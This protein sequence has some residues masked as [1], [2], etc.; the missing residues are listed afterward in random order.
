MQEITTTVFKFDELEDSAK[1]KAIENL[2]DINIFD[3]WHEFVYEDSKTIG[4]LMGISI[5]K[6]Y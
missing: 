1:D 6:I 2:W 5:N 4:E 3:D